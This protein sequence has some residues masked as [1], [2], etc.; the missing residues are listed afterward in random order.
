MKYLPLECIQIFRDVWLRIYSTLLEQ[1]LECVLFDTELLQYLFVAQLV[2]AFDSTV[3]F[4]TQGKVNQHLAATCHR[5][6]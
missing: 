3:E 6:I 1:P 2:H 4:F 5:S